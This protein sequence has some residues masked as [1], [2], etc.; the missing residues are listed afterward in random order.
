MTRKAT[1]YFEY[2]TRKIYKSSFRITFDYILTLI[3][4]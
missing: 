4:R 2:C 3:T 1:Q